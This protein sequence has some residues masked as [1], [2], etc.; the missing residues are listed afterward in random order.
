M[1][2]T[3]VPFFKNGEYAERYLRHNIVYNPKNEEPVPVEGDVVSCV[4]N[5]II[6]ITEDGKLKT[7]VFTE[8]MKIVGHD[9]TIYRVQKPN[10]FQEITEMFHS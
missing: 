7:L 5:T 8:S 6:H 2:K 9:D 1:V 10:L 3:L 4:G